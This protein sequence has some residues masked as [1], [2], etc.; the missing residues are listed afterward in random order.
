MVGVKLLIKQSQHKLEAAEPLLVA[1]ECLH[2]AAVVKFWRE[3]SYYLK[4]KIL[5]QLLFFFM[6]L[7]K[8]AINS[9]KRKLSFMVQ[10]PC[11]CFVPKHF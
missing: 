6:L 7:E 8:S 9:G 1:A 3:Q 4:E 10:N 11:A 5:F 2:S